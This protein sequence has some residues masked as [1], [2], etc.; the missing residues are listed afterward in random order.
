MY[1]KW[2]NEGSISIRFH[3]YEVRLLG[4]EATIQDSDQLI[5]KNKWISLQE[6]KNLPL[7]F[8]EDL[9]ILESYMSKKLN[10]LSI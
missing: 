3:Y 9:S 10:T 4:G 2:G 6:L 1:T 5:H 8:P 7:G